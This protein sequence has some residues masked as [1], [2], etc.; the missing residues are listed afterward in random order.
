MFNGECLVGMCDGSV[1]H[2]KKDPDEQ[3]MKYLIMPADGNVINI[4]V[5]K[6]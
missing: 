5:L 1:I 4:E 3:Q 2:L 6:Y